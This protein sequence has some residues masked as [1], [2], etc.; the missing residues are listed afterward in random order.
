[1]TSSN[2]LTVRWSERRTALRA[3]FRRWFPHCYSERRVPSSAVPHLRLVRPGPLCERLFSLPR[4][5]HRLLSCLPRNSINLLMSACCDTRSVRMRESAAFAFERRGDC[6]VNPRAAN[7][8]DKK[9]T[10]TLK[11]TKSPAGLSALFITTAFRKTL[12]FK[13][14]ARFKGHAAFFTMNTYP[15]RSKILD[16][17]GYSRDI[18]EFDLWD[19]RLTDEP[20][21]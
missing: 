11:L 21:L 19:I 17:V 8:R 10:V 1:M 14:A 15:V 2:G 18:E 3:T 16:A 12:R 5:S 4:S 9:N 7:G 20:T 6:L 13:G